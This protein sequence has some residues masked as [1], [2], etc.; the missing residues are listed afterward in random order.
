MAEKSLFFNSVNGDR[1]YLATDFADYFS[2]FITN[3]FF[4]GEL[5]LKVIA[6]AGDMSFVVKAGTAY[7]D[8]YMY[9][10]T[11]DLRL[12]VDVA[13]GVLNRIDRVV[14]QLSFIDR[15]IRTI[16]KKGV[17]ASSPV[18]PSVQRDADIY[19]LGIATISVPAGTTTLTQSSITDTRGDITVGGIV[20]NL[21]AEAN[22]QASNVSIDDVAGYFISKT[23]EEA[24]IELAQPTSVIK[25]NKDVND[26]YTSFEKK[27]PAGIRT[28]QSVLS[29]PNVDGYYLTRTIK[30]FDRDGTTIK[31]TMVTSISYD[32]D[33]EWFEEL[34]QSITI[35]GV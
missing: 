18:A 4:P 24:L 7:I 1:K 25:S 2:K 26:I 28:V 20:N 34:I 14:V 29:N 30:K 27:N 31:L 17:L 8:G 10:N 3:G 11:S 21:F 15:Q 9:N 13:D 19:E 12:S 6:D 16:I 22:A 23:V 32:P 35:A 5:N 33:G